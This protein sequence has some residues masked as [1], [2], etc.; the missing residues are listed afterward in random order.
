M[1]FS[2]PVVRQHIIQEDFYGTVW[3]NK[4]AG[5]KNKREQEA[6]MGQEI[7]FEVMY[8]YYFKLFLNIAMIF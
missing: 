1:I 6:G 3:F 7:P 5:K 8:P 2:E 4:K